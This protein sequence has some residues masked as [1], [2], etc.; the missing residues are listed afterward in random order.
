[1]LTQERL[2]ELLHYDQETGLFSRKSQVKGSSRK[3]GDVV[4]SD[5]GRGYIQISVDG[6]VYRAHRLAYL[7]MTGSMP[8][9]IDHWDQDKSNNRWENLRHAD[10]QKNSMNRIRQ[11]NNTS[12]YRGVWFDRRVKSN[13]YVAEATINGSKVSL[14][15]Y[16]TAKAAAEAYS[17]FAKEKHG[18]FYCNES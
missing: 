2:K 3:Q 6:K 1:M 15:R 5:D 9:I 16:P 12:G 8:N 14:G 7:F 18:E 11:A 10:M 17:K 4:G 13:P